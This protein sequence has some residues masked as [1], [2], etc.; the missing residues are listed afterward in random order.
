[1]LPISPNIHKYITT[2][3]EDKKWGLYVSGA[4][5]N[6]VGEKMEYPLRDHPAHHYFHMSEG[7]RLSEYQF[8]YITKGKGIF[9]TELIGKKT[10]EAG[11]LFI[12]F[13][14]IWHRFSPNKN[15]GWSEY[16]IEFN[17]KI[18]KHF[19]DQKFIDPLNPI[20]HIGL[21]EELINN[22]KKAT[23]LI[24][25]EEITSQYLL[26]GIIFQI[27]ILINAS[28]KL[29]YFEDKKTIEAKIIQAKLHIYEKMDTQIIL[30]KIANDLELSYSLFRKEFKYYTGLSPIQYQIELRIRKAKNLLE[31]SDQSLKD[32][33]YQLGF[34]S[35]NY[36]T[37]LFKKKV[38]MTPKEFRMRNIR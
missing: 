2:N 8:L 14:N 35:N 10:I 21:H 26:S 9:E 13:P 36:F 4:G 19:Q 29:R 33:A 20:I 30:S 25:N 34:D 17:G 16:W 22:F 12:L 32:I 37:R 1:M 27:N 18:A 6:E 7:R 28:K 5:Y 23:S 11:D 3:L 24:I 31:S 15:T 38:G